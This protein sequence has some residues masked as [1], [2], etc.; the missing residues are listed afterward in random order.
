MN[1]HFVWGLVAVLVLGGAVG[2]FIGKS[3]QPAKL[4]AFTVGPATA[5]GSEALY[6]ALNSMAG[7][8][9]RL[10]APLAGLLVASSSVSWGTLDT[11]DTASSSAAIALGGSATVGDFCHVQNL[12]AAS[13]SASFRCEVSAT[14]ANAS[15]TIYAIVSSSS[16]AVGT[17]TM[18]VWVL[19][20]SSFVAPAALNTVTSTTAGD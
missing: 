5:G 1:K 14:G 13:S 11:S 20:V 15:A 10:R 7:D 9:V 3:S 17:L 6:N 18:R 4:G 2:Y 12:T 16:A 8:D 19:P